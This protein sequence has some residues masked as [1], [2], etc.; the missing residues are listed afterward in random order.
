MRPRA[1]LLIVAAMWMSSVCAEAP[2]QI[3]IPISTDS[4]G[5]MTAPFL[6]PANAVLLGP[7]VRDT[8]QNADVAQLVVMASSVEGQHTPF[9]LTW[10][11]LDGTQ[12]IG[13]GSGADGISGTSESGGMDAPGATSRTSRALLFGTFDGCAG[14]TYALKFSHGPALASVLAA[15]PTIVIN[16]HRTLSF[17]GFVDDGPRLK[18][19]CSTR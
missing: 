4:R 7:R 14:R 12:A 5:E 16:V 17:S 19:L 10:T 2:P 13:K 18:T 8:I 9:D 15:S 6:I 1:A 11:V 3:R